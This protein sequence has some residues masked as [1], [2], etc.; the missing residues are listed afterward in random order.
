[1]S[2]TTEVGSASAI[3]LSVVT[4]IWGWIERL[5]SAIWTGL[6]WPHAV[7]I[8]FLIAIGCYRLEIK[9]LIERV[10]EFGP[11]GVKLQ[12]PVQPSP[13]ERADP[14]AAAVSS[15]SSTGELSPPP[16]NKGIP[17]P[18]IIVFPEQIK[19]WK[20]AILREVSDMSD[21]EAKS[22]LIPC[23]A[24]SRSMYVFE[25]CYSNIFGGQIRLLHILNQRIGKSVSTQEINYF[26]AAHQ[27]QTKPV[28]DLWSA[29]QYLSYLLQN[30]LIEK[31]EDLVKLTI[32]GAEFVLWL[33][34]FG[35]PLD[36]P[37]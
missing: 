8:I 7:L 19:F 33:T 34:H 15:S 29:D 21:T 10:L 18:E 31:T 30:G 27:E 9:A 13:L 6:G 22:Y 20:E 5:T 3:I 17:M 14:S 2:D 25:F 32:K 11:A 12:P 24:M 16:R 23:L 37:W 36:K 26:W 1:M 4:I 28:L 35:R